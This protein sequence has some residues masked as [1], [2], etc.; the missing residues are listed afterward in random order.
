MPR[1]HSV[2]KPRS[3]SSERPRLAHHPPQTDRAPCALDGCTTTSATGGIRGLIYGAVTDNQS[4]PADN[5]YHHL[6][7][8]VRRAISCIP[9]LARAQ[10]ADARRRSGHLAGLGLGQSLRRIDAA[11][12]GQ[13]IGDHANDRDVRQHVGEKSTGRST[14][15]KT[16][17]D[18]SS[19]GGGDGCARPTASRAAHARSCCPRHGRITSSNAT[20]PAAVK[21]PNQNGAQGPTRSQSKPAITLLARVVAPEPR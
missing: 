15:H 1:E 12:S 6:V 17:D 14:S 16:R 7:R 13:Q 4:P 2:A 20:A 18:A 11:L 9:T 10:I 21:P 19:C 3:S 5:R 8:S